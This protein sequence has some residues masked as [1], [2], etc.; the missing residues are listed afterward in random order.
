MKRM[1]QGLVEQHMRRNCILK[2]HMTSK[3]EQFR[4]RGITRKTT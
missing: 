2:N 3:M 1:K 4:R